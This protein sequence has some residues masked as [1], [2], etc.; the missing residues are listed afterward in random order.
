MEN[1]RKILCITYSCNWGALRKI[2][3]NFAPLAKNGFLTTTIFWVP[4]R[5]FYTVGQSMD[6]KVI[7][8]LNKDS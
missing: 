6:D 2:A 5:V 7:S 3:K 4:H 8:K 1:M